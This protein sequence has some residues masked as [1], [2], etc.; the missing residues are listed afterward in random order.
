MQPHLTTKRNVDLSSFPI[1]T[2]QNY[3]TNIYKSD[4]YSAARKSESIIVNF[5]K[6]SLIGLHDS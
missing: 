3:Y 2:T 6:V 4:I 5:K 1:L